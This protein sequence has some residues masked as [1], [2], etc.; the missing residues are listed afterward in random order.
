MLWEI[1]YTTHGFSQTEGQKQIICG[2]DRDSQFSKY[3]QTKKNTHTKL[4]S[5]CG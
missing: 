5:L 3:L 1:K 4:A 2:G